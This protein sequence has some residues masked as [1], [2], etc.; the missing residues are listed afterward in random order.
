MKKSALLRIFS[1]AAKRARRSERLMR[2]PRVRQR[3]EPVVK[4]ETSP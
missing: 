2:K 3:K 4:R 1:A